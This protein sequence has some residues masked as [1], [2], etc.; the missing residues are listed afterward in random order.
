M[1]GLSG[2]AIGGGDDGDESAE[3]GAPVV[4]AAEL[5]RVALIFWKAAAD[6][7]VTAA[8]IPQ[9]VGWGAGVIPQVSRRIYPAV[10]GWWRPRSCGVDH[11]SGAYIIRLVVGARLVA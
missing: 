4:V 7:Y 2:E 8:G 5:G 9:V 10:V 3:T 1:P 6:G 11:V